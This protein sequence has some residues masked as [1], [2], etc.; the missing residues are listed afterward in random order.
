MLDKMANDSRKISS[1]MLSLAIFNPAAAVY[2]MAAVNREVKVAVLANAVYY[3]NLD[4]F[5]YRSRLVD[6]VVATA[7]K[8][9]TVEPNAQELLYPRNSP[10]KQSAFQ[11][12]LGWLP[13]GELKMR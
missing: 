1:D 2:L 6:F 10:A 13:N 4:E 3:I 7:C 11:R 9:A 12:I 5:K 8:L